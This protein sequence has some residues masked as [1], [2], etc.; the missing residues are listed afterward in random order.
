M[1]NPMPNEDK[2]YQVLKDEK[3]E[4][5]PLIWQFLDHHIRNDLF[6]IMAIVEDL[7]DENQPLTEGEKNKI[8]QRIKNITS[9]IKK[10]K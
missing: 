2:L 9:L 10:L 8:F 3:V 4:V 5:H 7:A 1:A 6:V